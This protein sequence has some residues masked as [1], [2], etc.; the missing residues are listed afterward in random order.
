MLRVYVCPTLGC[1]D[2]YG[3]PDMED[4]TTRLTGPKTEDRHIISKEE[5]RVGI[6]GKRHTRAECPS[7][8]ERGEFVQR[9]LV[10]LPFDPYAFTGVKTAA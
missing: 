10:E 8:R 5:S 2:Y 6:A 9:E 7:C 4:L 3:V 1:G